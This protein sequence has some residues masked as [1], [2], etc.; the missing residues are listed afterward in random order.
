MQDHKRLYGI[1][2]RSS[3]LV[4]LAI[5]IIAFPAIPTIE[6]KPYEPKICLNDKLIVD[7][8]ISTDEPQEPAPPQQPRRLP[9]VVKPADN[10][11]D[12]DDDSVVSNWQSDYD[13]MHRLPGDVI[14]LEPVKYFQVTIKPQPIKTSLPEYPEILRTAGIEGECV[15]WGIIDTTGKIIEAKVY[16]PANNRLF[17][18]AALAAFRNY[19]FTPGYQHDRTVRVEII[20]PFKFRLK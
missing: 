18:E 19:E 14:N 12:I 1:Y 4:S 17:D 3:M 8:F 5:T 15:I 11:G 2:I 9:P 7:D 16:H 6:V 20:M 10:V 13:E